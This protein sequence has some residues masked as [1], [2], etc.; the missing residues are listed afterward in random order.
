AKEKSLTTYPSLVGKMTDKDYPWVTLITAVMTVIFLGAYCAAQLVA[1][2]KIGVQLFDWDFTYFVFGGA[3]VLVA[4]CWSGGIRA[5][6]WTDAVQ[7]FIIIFSLIVLIV[8]AVLHIGGI[9][10][11]INEVRNFPP[12]MVNPFQLDFL[13]V[14]IGWIVFGITV[15]GQPHLMVRHMCARTNKDIDRALKIYLAWRMTVLFLACVS[16]I[17]ARI[18][19]P[20]A[21]TFDPELSIPQLWQDL[22]PPVLVGLLIAGLFSATMSSADSML[23]SASSALTQHVIPAFRNS[24]MLA[25]L[26]TVLVITIVIAISLFAQ[27]GVLALVIIAWGGL[28]SSVG[29]L[30]VVQLLGG[31]PSQKLAVTMMVVGFAT[32]VIWRYGLGWHTTLMELV[33]GFCAGLLVFGVARVFKKIKPTQQAA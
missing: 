10:A 25:R 24:Y 28:A 13:W 6:I 30:M 18:I 31:K 26:G 23:L 5:S 20:D 2:A 29:P 22:L 19:I 15:L 11:I 32:A 14:S 4:Y 1:G 9:G 8:A 27:K 3:A 21:G 16:G 12:E 7:A 33:P 17:L